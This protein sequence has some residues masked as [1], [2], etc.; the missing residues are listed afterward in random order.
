MM[1][2]GLTIAEANELN[3]LIGWYKLTPVQMLKVKHLVKKWSKP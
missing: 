1:I 3:D 2:H